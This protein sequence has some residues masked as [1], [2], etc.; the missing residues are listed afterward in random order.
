MCLNGFKCSLYFSHGAGFWTQGLMRTRQI[1]WPNSVLICLLLLRCGLDL[2]SLGPKHMACLWVTLPVQLVFKSYLSSLFHSPINLYI[3]PIGRC[4]DKVEYMKVL[5][6]LSSLAYWRKSSV[7]V[8]KWM[9]WLLI[10][11]QHQREI[12][13]FSSSQS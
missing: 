9:Y 13:T 12:R 10:W 1:L 3:F 11:K 4:G 2:V 5:G 7:S 6:S 8:R